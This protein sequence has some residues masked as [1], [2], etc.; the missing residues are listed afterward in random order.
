MPTEAILPL[1][2]ALRQTLGESVAEALRDAI[3]KGLIRPGQ[4]FS[5]AQIAERLDVS[6]APVRDALTQ[7]EQ[8]GLVFRTGSRG[9]AVSLL[10]RD[11]VEE[12]CTLRRALEG[13]AA[14]RV[15]KQRTDE[16]LDELAANIQATKSARSAE[17]LAVLDLQFH[18]MLVRGA[19]HGRLLA[20]WLNLRSQIRLLMVQRNL[21]DSGSFQGT[22]RGHSELLKAIRKCDE[23]LVQSL[24]DRQTEEQYR[25]FI[26]TFCP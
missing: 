22:V 18:E 2:P 5:E 26:D 20:G 19:N 13:L 6:R 25:W 8:E 1:K 9:I 4:H 17:Q 7:L 3:F 11:D 10:S 21:A 14:Q 16:Q 15:I 24:L 12:I 23:P